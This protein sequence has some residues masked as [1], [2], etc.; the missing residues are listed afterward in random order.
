MSL[1]PRT[2]RTRTAAYFWYSKEFERAS[3]AAV[4]SQ[5]V[6]GAGGRAH[7]SRGLFRCK[8]LLPNSPFNPAAERLPTISGRTPRRTWSS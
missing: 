4:G 6:R 5:A 3:D 8:F 1:E 2:R 7:V